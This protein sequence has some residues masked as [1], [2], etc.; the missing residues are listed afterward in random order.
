MLYMCFL[1]IVRQISAQCKEQALMLVKLWHSYF[2]QYTDSMRKSLYQV[3]KR[4]RRVNAL[5]DGL[6]Q[7]Y[8]EVLDTNTAKDLEFVALIGKYEKSLEL[9]EIVSK[10]LYDERVLTRRLKLEVADLRDNVTTLMPN[11]TRYYKDTQLQKKL[12]KCT[13][14]DAC[15]TWEKSER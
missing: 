8:A 14:A 12:M 10:S 11:H 7:K 15:G 13:I 6:T 5:L 9:L 3:N 2:D 4:T 1:E